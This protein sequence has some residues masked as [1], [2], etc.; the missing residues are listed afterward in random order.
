MGGQWAVMM[1]DQ[2]NVFAVKHLVGFLMAGYPDLAASE[3][4][5]N[6]LIEE[7]AGVLEIGVPF[8]DPA[9]DGPVLQRAAAVALEHGT[10]LAD[11]LGMVAR[12]RTRHPDVP[13]VL[14]TYLNPLLAYGLDEYARD[15]KKAGVSATLTVDLP[16]EEAGEYLQVH[17]RHGLGTVFLASPTTNAGRLELIAESSSFFVYYV[18][19]TGVT[20]EQTRV[21]ET[22]AGEMSRVRS[23]TSKPVAVG[24]G[25]A[26]AAHAAEIAK[27][28]DAVV[29]GSAFVRLIAESVD[30]TTAERSVRTFA[31]ACVAALREEGEGSSS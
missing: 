30:L 23:V 5:A 12:L 29:I 14:F 25:V 20:G 16:P 11:V 31:R 10:R 27:V 13:L 17:A 24:F 6:A 3:R 26:H 28:A 18:S 22:L 19:R 1:L 8:S 9:A 21:S 15:A 7:G 2:K 4:F